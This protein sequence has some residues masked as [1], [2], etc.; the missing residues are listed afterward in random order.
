MLTRDGFESENKWSGGL[1]VRAGFANPA[2]GPV[3]SEF[4][5]RV[6]RAHAPNCTD[7]RLST[8]LNNLRSVFVR[9]SPVFAVNSRCDHTSGET[10]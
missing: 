9:S 10:G 8:M 1:V 7:P 6:S 2:S 5:L 4:S 3:R